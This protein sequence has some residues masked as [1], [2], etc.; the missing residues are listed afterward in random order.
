MYWQMGI[1]Y[2][3]DSLKIGASMLF[4]IILL[5]IILIVIIVIGYIYI[6][7]ENKALS[8][9]MYDISQKN[10][11]DEFDGLKLVCLSDLHNNQF[12]NNNIRL[13]K[14]ID[15]LCPDYIVI[16]GDMIVSN[17]NSRQDISLE[18]LIELSK[19]YKIVYALGNHESKALLNDSMKFDR[20][21]DKLKATGVVVL[22]NTFIEFERQ[23]KNLRIYG[24][25]LPLELYMNNKRDSRLSLS[26][27][28]ITRN[29][30]LRD[31]T[32]CKNDM[33]FMLGKTDK[34]MYNVLLAHL[35]NYFKI[36]SEWGADLVFSGHIH[37]GVIILPFLGGVISPLYELFPKYDYGRFDDNGAVMVLSRGLGTHTIPV[38][39]FNKP[40]L[41]C[42][43]LSKGKG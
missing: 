43:R 21:I 7:L 41:I 25:E 20:Y 23:G 36:Y 11:P 9:T 19:R 28:D 16:A 29:E 39:I 31:K 1:I 22:R 26:K 4:T 42:V 37:G 10:L 27:S 33:E 17:N 2:V 32:L 8:V 30:M 15:E 38:R 5:M 40:E 35:P 3:L 6:R 34:N 13:I 18:L 12:G 24:L 14:K